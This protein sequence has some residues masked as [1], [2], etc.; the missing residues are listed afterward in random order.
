[1]SKTYKSVTLPSS[2]SISNRLLLLNKLHGGPLE[3]SNLSDAEDTLYLNK[4]LNEQQENRYVGQGGTSL[5]F[6]MTYFSSLPIT[7]EI[8]AE[9]RLLQRPHHT[10]WNALRALGADIEE[11]SSKNGQGYRI[12]GRDYQETK[13]AGL[14]QHIDVNTSSQFITALLLLGSSIKEG[15]NLRFTEGQMVS[16]PYV[17]LTIDLMHQLGLCVNVG[18]NQLSIAQQDL[19]PQK[20]QVEYDWSSVYA[21]LGGALLT[22]SALS[23]SGLK[24]DDIQGDR[25]LLKVY[26]A[27]GLQYEFTAAGLRID[28]SDFQSTTNGVIDMLYYP[29]QIMNLVVLL[30]AFKCQGSIRGVNTLFHKESNRVEALRVN[31]EKFGVSLTSSDS[32]LHFD[33]RRFIFPRKVSI[34]TFNDHRIAMAFAQLSMRSALTLN[35]S[36]CVKK[37]FPDFWN[38]WLLAF[39][40]SRIELK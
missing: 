24:R 38:Q 25:K 8:Y 19:T 31:L 5:R 3:L 10:L 11:F 32:K 40:E 1:M 23:I 17:S 18:R 30:S 26:H 7:T 6:A 28:L 16:K 2:K 21:F 39:P 27:M 13:T 14:T 34:D 4:V 20:I 22:K 35:D 36:Q 29:D 37:S 9:S 15:I 33:A 12:T